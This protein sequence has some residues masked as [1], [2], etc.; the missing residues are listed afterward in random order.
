M[1]GP[2]VSQVPAVTLPLK[3]PVAMTSIS[4]SCRGLWLAGVA[5]PSARLRSVQRAP[6]AVST[7]N[8]RCARR[9][10]GNTQYPMRLWP[11]NGM[12]SLP[13][14]SHWLQ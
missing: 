6:E 13:L 7:A 9:M 11:R 2:S 8:G 1:D 4:L 10:S 3:V 12:L 5:V 14:T